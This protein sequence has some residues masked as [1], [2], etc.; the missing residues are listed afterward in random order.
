M[1]WRENQNDQKKIEMNGARSSKI[2]PDIYVWE[3]LWYFFHIWQEKKEQANS[4]VIFHL[5]MIKI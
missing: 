4:V 3:I 5:T 2:A 1:R